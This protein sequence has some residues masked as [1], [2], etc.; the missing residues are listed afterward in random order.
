MRLLSIVTA[1]AILA[2]CSSA[3]IAGGSE[4]FTAH[5]D[6]LMP[7][8]MDR[9]G[10]PGAALAVIRPS[11]EPIVRTYGLAK[12]PGRPMTRN[13]M[14]HVGSISKPVT[15]WGVMS[16]AEAGR[17]DLDARVT[18]YLTSWRLPD[19]PRVL[20]ITVRQLLN[21]TAGL[22]IGTIG[23]H[24][25]PGGVMPSLRSSLSAEVAFD[26]DPGT[27]F[28]YSNVG[29]NLLE[30]LV[31]EVTGEAFADYMQREVLTPLGMA[32]AT[33]AW[34]RSFHALIPHG[35]DLDGSEVPPY[36]YPEKGSGGLFA[37]I[38]DIAAF[39]SAT[40][41][42]AEGGVLGAATLQAM[43]QPSTEVEG[44]YR[45]VTSEYGLG[46]FV[47]TLPGGERAVW[48]GG[49]GHGW[50]T[51]FHAI[52]ATG[53]GIVILTNSQR[54]WP[55]FSEVLR[56]W[57]QWVGVGP[58]GMSRIG[59]ITGW[60]AA[61]VVVLGLILVAR[62]GRVARDLA[63]GRRRPASP[64]W[65]KVAFG[66]LPAAAALFLWGGDPLYLRAVF[67]L[68]WPWFGVVSF[69]AAAVALVD[70]VSARTD[71]DVDDA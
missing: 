65:W 16:L 28:G 42:M 8:L 26:R 4:A 15:A 70:A 10:V 63:T 60:A 48:H 44:I 39:V 6:D 45:V 5:L 41:S 11:E 51:H 50:M 58:V 22:A 34:S 57:S 9:Y 29:F 68:L 56:D 24:Y 46:Y 7:R 62:L 36:V 67:P 31:E 3:P 21:H 19:D 47:E 25:E 53:D 49:Q 2:G 1:V 61:A 55:L 20:E 52:P 43:L 71:S 33:Y 18:R 23:V 32:S 66:L 30:L 14:D 38:D 40:M 59:T 27:G 69:G 37:T 12:V 64:S 13:A 35:Y 17:I 54:S